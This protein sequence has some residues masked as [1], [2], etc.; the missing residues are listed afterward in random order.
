LQPFSQLVYAPLLVTGPEPFSGQI[1]GFR[2]NPLNRLLQI[3]FVAFQRKSSPAGLS[4]KL[5]LTTGGWTIS[6]EVCL[7]TFYLSTSRFG[8]WFRGSSFIQRLPTDTDGYLHPLGNI[9]L[10]LLITG[11]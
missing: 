8:I 4:K 3:W 2:G 9:L 10:N 5:W 1:A 11:L 6:K 7:S